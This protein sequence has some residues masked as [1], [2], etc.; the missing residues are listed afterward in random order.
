R[1]VELLAPERDL[2]ESAA[3]AR[4]REI[5]SRQQGEPLGELAGRF[6]ELALGQAN[7]SQRRQRAAA[8]R[9]VAG[10]G[11]LGAQLERAACQLFGNV[12]TTEAAFDPGDRLEQ[13]GLHVGFGR[14]LL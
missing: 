4:G 7:R 12:E 8:G 2:G 1:L 13:A 11:A 9:G 10:A 6:V 5:V 3:R 14:E